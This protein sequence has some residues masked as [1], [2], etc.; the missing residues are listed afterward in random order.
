MLWG[1]RRGYEVVIAV[2]G[3]EG[4]SM[5][6]SENP[7]LIL[8]DMSLPIMNAWE[9]AQTLK[10]DT[11][12]NF[13]PIIALTAHAMVGQLVNRQPVFNSDIYAVGM[14]A[15]PALTGKLPEEFTI[16]PGTGELNWCDFA[17]VSYTQVNTVRISPIIC[18]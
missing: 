13:I 12:T 17:N 4:V 8:M 10:T 5:A 11:S 9:A 2:D 14:I 15:L 6:M 1:R 3:A 16:N 7:D 18:S